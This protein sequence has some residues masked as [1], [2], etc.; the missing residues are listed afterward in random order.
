MTVL[1]TLVKLVLQQYFLLLFL[2]NFPL[3]LDYFV[4]NFHQLAL[5]LQQLLFSLIQL[6]RNLSQIGGQ[7]TDLQLPR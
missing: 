3:H 7:V 1:Q 5:R 4:P 6:A 2:L